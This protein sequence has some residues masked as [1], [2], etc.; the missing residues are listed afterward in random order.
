MQA[1]K[2]TQHY[3]DLLDTDPNLKRWFQSNAKS[4]IIVAEV[5]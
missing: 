5:S 2:G 3:K 1:D 4:I